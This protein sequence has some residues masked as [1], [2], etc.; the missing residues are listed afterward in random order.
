MAPNGKVLWVNAT[1]EDWGVEAGAANGLGGGFGTGGE[2]LFVGACATAWF[3]E[4]AKFLDELAELSSDGGL[5]G[6]GGQADD[7]ALV[8]DGDV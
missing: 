8:D 6:L 7:A 5:L 3:Q 2:L 1:F 4:L